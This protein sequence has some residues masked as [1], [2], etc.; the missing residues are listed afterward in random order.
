MPTEPVFWFILGNL[1]DLS[2]PMYKELS[3]L[4]VSYIL[5]ASGGQTDCSENWLMKQQCTSSS[6]Q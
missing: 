5:D 6:S 4:Q 3:F 1:D 2:L